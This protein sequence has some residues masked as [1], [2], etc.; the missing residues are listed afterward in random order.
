MSHHLQSTTNL[1]ILDILIS[2]LVS[3]RIQRWYLLMKK[4]KVKGYFIY[5]VQLKVDLFS[6]H[7]LLVS[8]SELS[9]HRQTTDYP[10]TRS[11]CAIALIQLWRSELI[12]PSSL[13]AG[14]VALH[15]I[16]SRTMLEHRTIIPLIRLVILV[17]AILTCAESSSQN[18]DDGCVSPFRIVS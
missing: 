11:G 6:I 4:Y 17:V 2:L 18:V 14:L 12:H 9:F 1:Y 16:F 10:L 15:L 8:L 7:S 13:L 3:F 5:L